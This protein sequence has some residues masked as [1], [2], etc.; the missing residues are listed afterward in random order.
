MSNNNKRRYYEGIFLHLVSEK[1]V[2]RIVFHGGT[3]KQKGRGIRIEYH[4][5]KFNCGGI[6]TGDSGQFHHMAT[7]QQAEQDCEWVIEAPQGKHIQLN[8][9]FSHWNLFKCDPGDTDLDIYSNDT[10]TEGQLLLR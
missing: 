9:H 1:N 5:E 10:S 6:L 7:T 4:F 8:V 2:L 3:N